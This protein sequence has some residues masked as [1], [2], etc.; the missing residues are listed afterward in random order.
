MLKP[1][2]KQNR[3][4]LSK[5][6][7][8][9]MTQDPT[10]FWRRFVT[11]DETWIHQYTPESRQATRVWTASDERPPT[12]VRTAT[13]T[14]KTLATVFWDM[15]GILLIDYMPTGSTI[16]GEYYARLLDQLKHAIVTKRPGLQRKKVLIHQDN[17]PAHTSC[18]AMAK[19]AEWG[20]EIV[21]HLAYSADLAPS[22]YFLF[23]NLKSY[24]S[25][26]RYATNEEVISAVHAYFESQDSTFY[27][28]GIHALRDR[29]TRALSIRGK[30]F[31]KMLSSY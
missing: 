8:S 17:A 3:V 15:H 19:V 1:D 27:S 11:V 6:H 30:I 20:F 13:S 23:K 25:G 26:K 12:L 7:L 9:R 18:V 24:L 5:R 2:Q 21:E 14:K 16:T 10:D 28:N 31:P 29:W 4:S 22:D